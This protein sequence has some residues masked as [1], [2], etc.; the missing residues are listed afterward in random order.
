MTVLGAKEPNLRRLSR[1]WSRVEATAN[2]QACWKWKGDYFYNHKTDSWH[3]VIPW[4]A[5]WIDVGTLVYR[6]WSKYNDGVLAT[7]KIRP[8]D[9]QRTC[10]QFY[11]VNPRHIKEKPRYKWVRRR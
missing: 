5:I 7:G 9:I 1:F 11:C 3:P 8:A 6:L 4:N 2:D 10:Q